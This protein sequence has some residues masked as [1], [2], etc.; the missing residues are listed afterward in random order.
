VYLSVII[1]TLGKPATACRLAVRMHELF[2]SLRVETIVVTPPG[3]R[4]ARCRASRRRPRH[5]LL[6][7][8]D[9]I[10]PDDLSPKEALEVFYSLRTL[11][12]R[13]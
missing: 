3:V 8:L 10:N 4:C 2:P 7:A 9:A 12:E 5:A 6:A 13:A 1:A 11:R